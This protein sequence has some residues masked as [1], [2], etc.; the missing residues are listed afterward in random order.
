MATKPTKT[1]DARNLAEWRKWLAR[2]HKTE[3]EVWL[4]FYKQ[5]TG[6]T[7]VSYKDAL[8]EALCFG[9][10]D[11]LVRRL[12]DAR[13]ARKFTPR[14]RD[15]RWSDINRKRYAELKAEGRMQPAGTERPPTDRAY[16]PRP[17]LPLALPKYIE[18]GLKAHPLAW[19]H[20]EKLAPSHRRHYVGWIHIAKRRET[21]ERRLKEAIKLLSAGK[22]LGLK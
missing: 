22:L 8:D 3:S 2:H 13:Y 5:H 18:A 17:S 15:S 9:W 1:I 4:V 11:S 14:K 21:K 16:G 6:R 19:E 7:M 20:F 10:I 12:D